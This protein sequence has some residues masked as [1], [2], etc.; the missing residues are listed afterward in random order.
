MKPGQSS[1]PRSG[2]ATVEKGALSLAP[3]LSGGE[4]MT[5]LTGKRKVEAMLGIKRPAQNGAASMAPP[6]ARKPKAG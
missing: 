1:D 5:P 6:P 3:S 2:I 4:S